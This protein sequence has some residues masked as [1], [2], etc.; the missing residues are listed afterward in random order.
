MGR[1]FSEDFLTPIAYLQP[2]LLFMLFFSPLFWCVGMFAPKT[3][4][5]II[6]LRGGGFN[7]S[8]YDWSQ[9]VMTPLRSTNAV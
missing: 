2:R 5:N 1:L 4:E 6:D 9:L 3:G 7:M 8:T